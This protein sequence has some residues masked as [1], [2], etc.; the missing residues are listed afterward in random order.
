MTRTVSFFFAAAAGFFFAAAPAPA[1]FF[2]VGFAD[3][4]DDEAAA[5]DG[6]VFADDPMS[7][8]ELL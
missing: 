8:P 3:S 4:V 5:V 2:F 1:P 6:V 7:S